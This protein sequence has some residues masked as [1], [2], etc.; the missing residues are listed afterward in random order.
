MARPLDH[1]DRT[2]KLGRKR[3]DAQCHGRNG[4]SCSP[5]IL[6]EDLRYATTYLIPDDANQPKTVDRLLAITNFSLEAILTMWSCLPRTL[7]TRMRAND[8][9][10]SRTAEVDVDRAGW[11]PFAL[12]LWPMSCA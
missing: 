7:A 5:S 12:V 3:N 1:R 6:F 2:M 11:L 9:K 8:K 4:E 10:Q